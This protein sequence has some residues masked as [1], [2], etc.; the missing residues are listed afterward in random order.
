MRKWGIV[1]SVFYARILLAFILPGAIFLA[2]YKFD[3][4]GKFL[5]TVNEAYGD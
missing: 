3:D 1:I 2:L 4:W 5:E